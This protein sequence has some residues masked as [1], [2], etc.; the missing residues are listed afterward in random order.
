MTILIALRNQLHDIDCIMQAE[1]RPIMTGDWRSGCPINLTLEALGDR[2]SLLVIRDMMFGNQRHFRELLTKSQEGIATNILA[3]RLKRL[4]EAGFLT[5]ADDP[6]HKQKAIYSLTDK[7]IQL[8]PLLAQMGAWGRRHMPVTEELS[9]RARILEEG[10]PEL[11]AEFMDELREVH[12]GLRRQANGPT[13]AERLQK[14]F[15]A[16]REPRHAGSDPGAKR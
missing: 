5:R 4:T 10:G 9:V 7:A 3:D 2:W 1:K 8:V 11:W 12:L 15:E 13:V 14:A 6:S 16:A